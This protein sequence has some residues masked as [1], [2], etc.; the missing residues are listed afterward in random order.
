MTTV[1]DLFIS[2]VKIETSNITCNDTTPSWDPVLAVHILATGTATNSVYVGSSY[3]TLA[4][5]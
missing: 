1:C 5:T 2:E 4:F 3:V